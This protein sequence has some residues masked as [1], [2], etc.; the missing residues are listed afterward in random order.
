MQNNE[1]KKFVTNLPSFPLD[2]WTAANY[3]KATNVSYDKYLEDLTEI[4]ESFINTQQEILSDTVN[5]T[6]ARYNIFS[7]SLD[8]LIKADEDFSD[9]LLLI[10][11][12]DSQNIPL[13]LLYTCKDKSI[14][15]KFII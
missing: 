9:L 14:V 5:Y 13:N 3:I 10:S 1:V 6:T 2:I 12:I 7:I 4:N 15:D 8:K 11:L